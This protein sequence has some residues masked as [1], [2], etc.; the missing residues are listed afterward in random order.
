MP[1]NCLAKKGPFA[2]MGL[3]WGAGGREAKKPIP[4]G[5]WRQLWLKPNK[6]VSIA[7][8]HLKI[9]ISPLGKPIWRIPAIWKHGTGSKSL[10]CPEGPHNKKRFLCLGHKKRIPSRAQADIFMRKQIGTVAFTACSF[11]L[12]RRE[13]AATSGQTAPPPPQPQL[14]ARTCLFLFPIY[15]SG[16]SNILLFIW[17]NLESGNW[18]YLP[19][20][21]S[22][23]R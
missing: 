7:L 21:F 1:L 3:T 8:L 22:Q 16:A 6:C 10:F 9:Y 14:L 18:V 19:C 12:T 5:P 4:P 11:C 23:C 13:N 15:P 2:A 20:V 17:G